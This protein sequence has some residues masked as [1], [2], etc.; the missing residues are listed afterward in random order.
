MHA[1]KE[2]RFSIFFQRFPEKPQN[3]CVES[4]PQASEDV[5]CFANHSA[6]WQMAEVVITSNN[7]N[8]PPAWIDELPFN[9]FIYLK[10]ERQVSFRGSGYT[11][12]SP[13]SKPDPW[14]TSWQN[15]KWS[16]CVSVTE[17][18]NVGDESSSLAAYAAERYN[19][20]PPYVI[21][22]HG[23]LRAWHST[24]I[25][26]QFSCVCL[27]AKLERARSL[28]TAERVFT[29]LCK[30][31]STPERA[32]WKALFE[33]YQKELLPS[34]VVVDCCGL[35]ILRRDVIQ[36]WPHTFWVALRDALLHQPLSHSGLLGGYDG[37]EFSQH[38]EQLWRY[39][40]NVTEYD[41][42]RDMFQRNCFSPFERFECATGPLRDIRSD[43][44]SAPFSGRP[45]A[46]RP[47]W[48]G[49]ITAW[50][51]E[52]VASH[53]VGGARGKPEFHHHHLRGGVPL[54][55]LLVRTFSPQVFV[56]LGE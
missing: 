55:A 54:L 36:A 56:K 46:P 20:L 49:R 51:A 30:Y 14:H 1:E 34:S 25:L 48:L 35:V 44:L 47:S 38:L 9:K 43:A 26:E 3:Y 23:H 52:R 28:M 6:P 33:P 24:N 31:L 29:I 11:Q 4:N 22:L 50:L 21:L 32:V 8:S 18:P 16:T 5:F 40:F 53:M 19:S 41:A 39:F 7:M 37:Q 13:R 15:A 2:K 42:Q 27:D 12:W 45:C 17:H 10:D